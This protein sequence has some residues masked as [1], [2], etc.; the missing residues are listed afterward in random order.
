LQ[1]WFNL[2]WF[3]PDFLAE[4]PLKDWLTREKFLLKKQ[5]DSFS[6]DRESYS[7]CDSASQRNA[8]ERAD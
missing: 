1:L 6:A 8:G 3:D 2:A 7:G 4:E 5:G